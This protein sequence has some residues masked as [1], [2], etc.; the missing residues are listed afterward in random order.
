LEALRATLGLQDRVR[1]MGNRSDVTRLLKQVDF[2]VLPSR[3][4]GLPI[5]ILE[6]M[7]AGCPIIAT[8]VDGTAEVLSGDSALLV[9]ADDWRSLAGAIKKYLDNPSLRDALAHRASIEAGEYSAERN[10]ERLFAVYDRVLA[11]GALN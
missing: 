5:I 4:E 11:R 7:A 3:Y 6:A 8:A 9:P 1:F 2:L 10:A